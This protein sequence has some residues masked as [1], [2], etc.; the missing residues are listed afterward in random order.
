LSLSKQIM[1]KHNGTLVLE[2]SDSNVTI[3]ALIFK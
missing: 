2:Q 1:V 3:F